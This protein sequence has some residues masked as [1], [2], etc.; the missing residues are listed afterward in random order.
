VVKQHR[1]HISVESSPGQGTVFTVLL[2]VASRAT[3]F[4]VRPA[5]ETPPPPRPGTTVL[6]VD[7]EPAIRTT[8]S[9][10]LR[11]EGYQVLTA[12]D[13]QDALR[14]FA[15]QPKGIDVVLLDW[16]MPNMGGHECAVQMLQQNSAQKIIVMSGYTGG[17]N[18]DDDLQARLAGF[19]PKPLTTSQLLL[20]LGQAVARSSSTPAAD[21]SPVP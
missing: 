20:M 19:L 1:G 8:M 7:D 2:P 9:A 16:L 15:T 17:W 13:G 3:P 11:R 12:V 18:I 4:K 10:L 5:L 6:L 21:S 14:V